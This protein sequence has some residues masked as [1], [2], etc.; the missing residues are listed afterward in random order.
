MTDAPRTAI[1]N[2]KTEFNLKNQFSNIDPVT[3]NRISVC[4]EQPHLNEGPADAIT[5]AE[6]VLSYYT[7]HN[8]FADWNTHCR[9]QYTDQ[10]RHGIQA[11]WQLKFLSFF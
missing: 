6:S 4:E 9:T 11:I 5:N 3:P 8:T 7:K 10:Y 1:T 2:A